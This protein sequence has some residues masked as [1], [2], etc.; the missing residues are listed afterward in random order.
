MITSTESTK[1]KILNDDQ[2]AEVTRL[3][4]EVKGQGHNQS[5]GHAGA[6]SSAVNDLLELLKHAQ[7][8][9]VN[10]GAEARRGQQKGPGSDRRKGP[11]SAGGRK[12]VQFNPSK[13]S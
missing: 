4:N 6:N 10:F 11:A 2:L 5:Q 3:L 8:E 9:T 7:G 13:V 12:N 1:N